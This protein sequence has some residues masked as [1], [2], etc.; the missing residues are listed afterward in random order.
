MDVN[1]ITPSFLEGLF[2]NIVTKYG[3]E[4]VLRNVVFTGAYRVKNAF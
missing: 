2:K 3:K 4:T 1:S